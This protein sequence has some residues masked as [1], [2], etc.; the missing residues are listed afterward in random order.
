[1]P[2]AENQ[3]RDRPECRKRVWE[4]LGDIIEYDEEEKERDRALAEYVEMRQAEVVADREK[5]KK[6]NQ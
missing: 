5:K 2:E 4:R 6:K 3:H 1:M